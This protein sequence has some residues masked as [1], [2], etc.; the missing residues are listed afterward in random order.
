[1]QI[2]YIVP[3]A[4]RTHIEWPHSGNSVK[5]F[6]NVAR[7]TAGRPK[8]E[9]TTGVM[10]LARRLSWVI[11]KRDR[12]GVSH[13]GGSGLTQTGG[14]G[15]SQTTI[16]ALAE[17]EM[18]KT[19]TTTLTL[20]FTITKPHLLRQI[21]SVFTIRTKMSERVPLTSLLGR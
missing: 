11:I 18:G 14:G 1:M 5:R 7:K 17:E 16:G 6:N 13:T 2:R 4:E 10:T 9:L 20:T 21:Y 8:T 19:R 3:F 12:S 15:V